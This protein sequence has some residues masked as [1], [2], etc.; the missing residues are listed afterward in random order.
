MPDG[1]NKI[2]FILL[3]IQQSA[4][5]NGKSNFGSSLVYMNA[6]YNPDTLSHFKYNHYDVKGKARIFYEI[7]FK[8]TLTRLT[9]HASVDMLR[10]DNWRLNLGAVSLD[11]CRLS[12]LYKSKNR[13]VKIFVK[14]LLRVSNYRDCPTF[15]NKTIIVKN[16]TVDPDLFPSFT[17]STY[18]ICQLHFAVGKVDYFSTFLKGKFYNL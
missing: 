2:F 16:Y 5:C 8:E 17:P 9:L 6:S 12:E 1:L 13:L 14:E 7:Q 4:I 15:P 10:A 18:W 11:M 3:I